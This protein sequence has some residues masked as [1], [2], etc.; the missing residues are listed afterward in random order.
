MGLHWQ[1]P[2]WPWPAGSK[3]SRLR[4]PLFLA[5]VGGLGH[6]GGRGRWQQQPAGLQPNCELM[7]LF[8]SRKTAVVSRDFLQDDYKTFS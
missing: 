1:A 2:G 8:F 6:A 5:L 3:P 7:T 4:R